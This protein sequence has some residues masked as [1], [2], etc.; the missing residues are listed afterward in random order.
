MIRIKYKALFTLEF[1]HPF[2][3]SGKCPD[4]AMV[5]SSDCAALIRSL[6]LNFLPSDF[7][8]KLYAKVG[9]DDKIKNPLPDGTKFTFLLKLQNRQFQNITDINLIKPA[10]SYYYFDNLAVNL[11][12]TNEPLLVSNLTSKIVTDSDLLPFAAGNFAFSDNSTVATQN[13]ELNFTYSGEILSQTVN[14]SGNIFNYSFDLNKASTGRVKFMIDGAEKASFYSIDQQEIADLFGIVEVFHKSA[15]PAE[16]LFQNVDNSINIKN[17]K[18]A[19][20]N[21]ATKWRYIINRQFNLAVNSVTVGKTNGTAINFGLAAT[22]PPNTFIAVSNDPLK[23]TEEPIAGIKLTD[24][25][26]KVLIANLPNPPL[27]LIRTEGS[28]TFSD[29]LITI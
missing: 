14:N 13:G 4:I 9:D 21:R 24:D 25:T 22:P 7:G 1:I 2:Y 27:N 16:N 15:L 12:A 6:G 8:G 23:L 28:D 10:K 17:Y 11:S 18:I 29:I 3:R 5:P 26:N 19:F 20:A